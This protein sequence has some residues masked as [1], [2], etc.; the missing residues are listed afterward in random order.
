MNI[1]LDNTFAARR[2]GFLQERDDLP[3]RSVDNGDRFNVTD[4]DA[5]RDADFYETM[6]EERTE[7]LRDA[8]TT[9]ILPA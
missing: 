1:V 5:F 6:L 7:W 3:H 4:P 2:S 8:R 9:G